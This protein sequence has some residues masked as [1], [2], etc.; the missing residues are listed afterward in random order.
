M[1][2]GLPPV[3]DKI[4]SRLQIVQ[5]GFV[6]HPASY[7]LGTEILFYGGKAARA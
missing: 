5:T 1:V 4:F 2:R 6:L 3:T 7:L